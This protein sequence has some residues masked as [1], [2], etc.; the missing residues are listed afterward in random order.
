MY[1]GLCPSL[2][3][4]WRELDV[5]VLVERDRGVAM[6]VSAYEARELE[7]TNEQPCLLHPTEDK[8]FLSVFDQHR[9]R[10]GLRKRGAFSF[11]RTDAPEKEPIGSGAEFFLI[12]K[13]SG[14]G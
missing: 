13:G 7:N 6:P 12:F 14:R 4:M 5:I 3:F 11:L 2:G 8:Q 10:S 9:T 1:H